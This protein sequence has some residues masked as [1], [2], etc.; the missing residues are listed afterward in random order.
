MRPTL[1]NA[2]DL[3]NAAAYLQKTLAA[4]PD[5]LLDDDPLLLAGSMSISDSHLVI[6]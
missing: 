6:V 3:L 5:E 4:P 1:L 2:A